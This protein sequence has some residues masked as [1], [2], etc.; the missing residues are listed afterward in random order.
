[1]R[2]VLEETFEVLEHVYN[3]FDVARSICARVKM[4]EHNRHKA[5]SSYWPSKHVTLPCFIAAGINCVKNC[6][7]FIDQTFVFCGLVETEIRLMHSCLH[8]RRLTISLSKLISF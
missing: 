5:P 8:G 4:I 3:I 7:Y 2:G 6:I 1:M